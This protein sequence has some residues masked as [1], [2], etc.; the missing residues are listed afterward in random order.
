M[1]ISHLTFDITS[2]K[3]G[4]FSLQTEEQASQVHEKTISIK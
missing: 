2:M 1:K 3:K 4:A